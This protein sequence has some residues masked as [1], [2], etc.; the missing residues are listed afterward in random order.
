[1]KGKHKKL[2]RKRC[3]DTTSFGA[4]SRMLHKWWRINV[5]KKIEFK[6]DSGV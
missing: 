4:W 5:E 6:K 2:W 3:Q 1:M